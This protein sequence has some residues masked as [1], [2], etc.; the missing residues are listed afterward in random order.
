MKGTNNSLYNQ[1]PLLLLSY[2]SKNQNKRLILSQIAEETGLSI[3]S[4]HKTLKEFELMSLI[5]LEKVGRSTLFR[6]NKMNPLVKSFRVFDNLV[7]INDLVSEIKDISKKIILFGSCAVG[8]DT[9]DSDIDIFILT[10]TDLKRTV[11]DKVFSYK[12]DR[13]IRQVI[14]DTFELMEIEKNDK[15]FY[16]EVMKGI[17]IW[18]E[19]HEY[20]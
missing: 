13:E 6:I 9:N 3:G 4:V 15:V 11:E 12:S 17:V 1:N 20:D 18:E 7:D 5:H 2:L 19:S 10:D 16:D 14:V 8:T